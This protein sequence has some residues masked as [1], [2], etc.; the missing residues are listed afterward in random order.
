MAI[1][2]GKDV[3]ANYGLTSE[4]LY[5]ADITVAALLNGYLLKEG[6]TLGKD[7]VSF[8]AKIEKGN[9]VKSFVMS[10]GQL[11]ETDKQV[12]D[13]NMKTGGK[14]LDEN[15]YSGIVNRK[16]SVTIETLLS[17]AKEKLLNNKNGSD[18]VK[19]YYA[20]RLALVSNL[21][22]NRQAAGESGR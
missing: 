22:K 19:N 6:T 10:E 2:Y 15:Y 7:S 14:A 16:S 18:N 13:W 1:E 21:N 5:K 12:I 9:L 11:S 4:E 20:D 17:Y 8:F 3:Q